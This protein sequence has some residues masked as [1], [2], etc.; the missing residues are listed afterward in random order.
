MLTPAAYTRQSVLHDA[1][2]LLK[3]AKGECIVRP[4]ASGEKAIAKFLEDEHHNLPFLGLSRIC[5]L[6]RR[7]VPRYAY[8]GLAVG[9][10]R[11][12]DTLTLSFVEPSV[13]PSS[14]T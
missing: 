4:V 3:L 1:N 10:L 14:S 11:Q 13:G 12:L 6:F 7:R 5:M 8:R 2:Y 9:L